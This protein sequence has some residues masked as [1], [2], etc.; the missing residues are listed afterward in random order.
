MQA[1]TEAEAVPTAIVLASLP[2]SD[3]EAAAGEVPLRYERWKRLSAGFKLYGSLSRLKKRLKSSVVAFSN[4]FA[5]QRPE[6][7]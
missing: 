4:Q 7:Q 2:E 6:M 3:V 5:T 1:L